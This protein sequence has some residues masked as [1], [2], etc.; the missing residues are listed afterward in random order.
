MTTVWVVLCFGV[1][2]TGLTQTHPHKTKEVLGVTEQDEP[3]VLIRVR[4]PSC[5]LKEWPQKPKPPFKTETS[6]ESPGQVEPQLRRQSA[7]ASARLLSDSPVAPQCHSQA[8]G[9]PSSSSSS[10]SPCRVETGVTDG[11][12]PP[13]TPG[14]PQ[15]R[16]SRQPHTRLPFSFHPPPTRPVLRG[17]HEKPG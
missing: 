17:S 14:R 3:L 5:R 10:S 16:S 8:G 13:V 15:R 4:H 2:T 9:A 11:R 1:Q 7:S 12:V 6:A